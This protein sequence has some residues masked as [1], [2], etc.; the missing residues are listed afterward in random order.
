MF[1][2]SG[3]VGA[4]V[5]EALPLVR[6]L[7]RRSPQEGMSG[8]GSRLSIQAARNHVQ[9]YESLHGYKLR[10]ETTWLENSPSNVQGRTS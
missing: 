10:F 4:V 9:G 1:P 2:G 5:E 3:E 8:M 7:R 6:T